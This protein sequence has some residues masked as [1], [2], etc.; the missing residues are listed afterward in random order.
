[1]HKQ[2]TKRPF[3]VAESLYPFKS[4]WIEIGGVP[5][6]YLDEGQGPTLLLLHGNF[7][8]SFSYRN[9]IKELRRDF[10]CIAIDLPGMG[11]SGKPH[12]LGM[13]KTRYTYAEQSKAVEQTLDA[14]DL[15][16]ITFLAYDHG[17]PIGF[18]V[19]GRRPELFSKFLIANT[20][21]W[22]NHQYRATRIWSALAPLSTRVL[23]ALLFH[24]EKWN[25]EPRWALEESGVWEACIAPY[26]RAADLK[27][28]A[29]LAG[30]LTNAKGYFADVERGIAKLADKPVALIWATEGGGLF[31]EYVA[32]DQF[33]ARWRT[34]FPNAPVTRMEGV[35]Y[36]FMAKPPELFL[37]TFRDFAKV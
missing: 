30:Q 17:G 19:A 5:I 15:K 31:P 6:H 27:P 14:L 12:Q 2:A 20:W 11:M 9:L 10:R 25:F 28:M 33:L 13:G 7:M 35:G 22:S 34:L 36:Y 21:A 8:W 3:G 4:N 16:D 1:M 23:K 18:G 26:P 32:E 29:T 24:K 37:K